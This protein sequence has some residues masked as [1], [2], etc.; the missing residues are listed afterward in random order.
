M[1]D[2]LCPVCRSKR[3]VRLTD[4]LD[5]STHIKLA[6]CTIAGAGILYAFN[7]FEAALKAIVFYLPMWAVAEFIHGARMREAVKCEA[8]DF[9]PF[10]YQRD[11]R[12]ARARVEAKLT[13]VSDDLKVQ[14]QRHMPLPPKAVTQQIAPV[15][16]KSVEKAIIPSAPRDVQR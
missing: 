10:L 14:I 5:F 11:W 16:G 3:N 13:L 2:V 4:R 7:G 8:C 15:I 12:A 9:D 6:L 1:G